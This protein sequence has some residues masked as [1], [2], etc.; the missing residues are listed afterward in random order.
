MSLIL[1]GSKS[2]LTWNLKHGQSSF[3]QIYI[4]LK[5]DIPQMKSSKLTAL[6]KVVL[7]TLNESVFNTVK[8]SLLIFRTSPPPPQIIQLVCF[9]E[10]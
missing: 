2:S 3:F 4:Q 7:V 8:R 6:I 9:M 5:V 10:V 1:C